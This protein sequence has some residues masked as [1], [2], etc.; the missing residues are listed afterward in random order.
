M[1]REYNDYLEDYS[2]GQMTITKA[3]VD[4]LKSYATK[5]PAPESP[6]IYYICANNW[7][8]YRDKAP[9]DVKYLREGMAYLVS[10]DAP[11]YRVRV[12]NVTVKNAVAYE[13]YDANGKLLRITMKG[14]RN[15]ANSN[16]E[17]LYP[18]GSARI[19]AVGWDGTRMTVYNVPN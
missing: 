4:A 1:L 9:L 5:Y 18:A 16:T 12:S 15:T 14:F 7:E 13:T 11:N 8:I 19:D 6:V 2:P 17:V 3:Q 10:Y